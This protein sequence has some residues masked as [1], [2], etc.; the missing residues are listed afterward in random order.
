[1]P[2]L[3]PQ[4]L[5]GAWSRYSFMARDRVGPDANDG[6]LTV[7]ELRSNLQNLA[8]ERDKNVSSGVPTMWVDSRITSGRQLLKDMKENGA[9]A[10]Q[11][12][13]DE[14]MDLPSSLRHRAIELLKIDDSTTSGEIDQYVI[15]HARGRYNGMSPVA[16][17]HADKAK[18]L[19]EI[20]KIAEHL[21][22][23]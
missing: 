23:D 1:M 12:L 9:T 6:L 4:D 8:K 14:V 2:I 7:K 13:S 19:E 16:A 10:V 11:Y 3:T 20:N 5:T 22:L 17:H 15:D 18:A 21:G